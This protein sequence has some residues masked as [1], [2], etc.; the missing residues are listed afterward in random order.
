MTESKHVERH[1]VS[2]KNSGDLKIQFPTQINTAR[3]HYEDQSVKGD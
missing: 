1:T 2:L 3:L